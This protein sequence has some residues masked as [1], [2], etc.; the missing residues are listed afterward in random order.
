MEGENYTVGGIQT[1]I[2]QL[3][4]VIERRDE[5]PVIVQF[6]NRNFKKKYNNIDVHGVKVNMSSKEKKKAKILTE[7]VEELSGND[8]VIIFATEDLFVP[9]SIKHVIAI[10]HGVGWDI[11]NTNHFTKRYLLLEVIRKSVGNYL[12][13][14]KIREIKN[15]VSV[16]YNFVNWYR[17][18]VFCNKNAIY[19]IPNST[20][21]KKSIPAKEKDIIRIMFARRFVQVR[22]TRLFSNV[23]KVIM[24]KYG[25]VYVTFAGEGPDEGYLKKM[26]NKNPKVEFI[27]YKS[28]NSL[29]FHQKHHIA[30]VPTLGSEGTSLS[31]LE[32]MASKCAV[33]ATNIGGMA[34]ILID[35]YNGFLI[36][37]DELELYEAIQKLILNERLRERLSANAYNTVL[38]GFNNELWE[39]KWSRIIDK[40]VEE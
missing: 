27:K 20:K 37:P 39:K 15:I 1:Y 11:P 10:Q 14:K 19:P 7:F 35:N 23:I 24:E 18:Q 9:T 31:L 12:R 22:G 40:V 36:N 33:V 29:E 5:V 4:K 2:R 26:F 38:E 28:E 25:N 17:T 32:A 6:S 8:D 3:A 13:L 30:V 21:I 34:N 16:D